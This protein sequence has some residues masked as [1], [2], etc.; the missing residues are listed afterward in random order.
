VAT[1]VPHTT[2]YFKV[3]MSDYHGAL[4]GSP[5]SVLVNARNKTT[6]L[7]VSGTELAIVESSG[8]KDCVCGEETKFLIRSKDL[9]LDVQITSDYN[10][11]V[12][13]K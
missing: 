2:G 13:I 4:L 1:F 6:P 10:F 5:F 7:T 12:F 9:E 3:F 11:P 8:I